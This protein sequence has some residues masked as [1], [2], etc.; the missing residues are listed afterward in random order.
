[1][2]PRNYLISWTILLSVLGTGCAIFDPG[3]ELL[4][5]NEKK[6]EAPIALPAEAVDYSELDGRDYIVRNERAY[7]D[8]AAAPPPILEE[9]IDVPQL[10]RYKVPTINATYI[11]NGEDALIMHY[12]SRIP[13]PDLKGMIAKYVKGIEIAELPN[14][15]TLVLSGPR[16]AFG[17]FASL[18]SVLNEFDVP[19]EQIRVRLRIVEYFN[20]NTYDRELV[21]GILRNGIQIFGVDLPSNETGTT[22]ETGV[23]FDPFFNLPAR[24]ATTFTG[25]IKFLDSHGKATTLSDADLLISNGK[26]AEL[27]NLLSVPFP[28]TVVAGNTVVE[29]IRYRDIGSD[30]KLTPYANEE[31]FITIKLEKSESGEQT[32]F[33]GTKQV[34]VFRSANLQSEFTIRDGETYFAGSILITRYTSIDRG[35]PILNRIPLIRSVTTSREI[36][37]NESQLLYFIEARVIPRDSAV[38]IR[39]GGGAGIRPGSRPDMGRNPST[40]SESQEDRPASSNS[41]TSTTAENSEEI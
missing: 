30:I 39:R 19:P 21:L 38:G 2:S 29:T 36:E 15:N 27:K 11:E 40:E 25:L 16:A 32:G 6:N 35:I 10:T 28:E 4:R 31:G 22:L 12:R 3:H 13:A 37:N 26:S 23:S 5:Y 33:V 14:Q 9:V 41:P 8:E 24:G 18:S 1:M 7:L 20:D 34:P 17:D